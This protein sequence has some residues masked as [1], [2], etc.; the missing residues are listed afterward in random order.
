MLS[1]LILQP[2]DVPSESDAEKRVI[3]AIQPRIPAGSLAFPEIPAGMLDDSG[4]FSGGAAKEIE[5]ETGLSV[6]EDELVDMIALTLDLI[7]QQDTAEEEEVKEKLQDGVYPSPGGSDEFIPLFL[8]QKCMPR[9]EIEN[10]QGQLT[11]LRKEG[12][13]ITLK[14][15]PLEELWKEGVR[16]GKT[17]AAFALYKGLKAEGKV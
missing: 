12:E 6:K 13:K 4:T 16:D 10:L 9:G 11:G 3:L 15:V 14:L 7:S 17:L 5:E 2:D 8:C 1:Q